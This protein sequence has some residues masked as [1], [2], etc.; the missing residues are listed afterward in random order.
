MGSTNTQRTINQGGSQVINFNLL[1]TGF[2]IA[3]AKA[4]VANCRDLQAKRNY[5][6][7]ARGCWLGFGQSDRGV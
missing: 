7:N 5:E 1:H 2:P 3:H 4:S 6:G